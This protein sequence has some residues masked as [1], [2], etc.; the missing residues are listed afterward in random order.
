MKFFRKSCI[1]VIKYDIDGEEEALDL[2]NRKEVFRW[3]DE[4]G[5]AEKKREKS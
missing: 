5:V 2:I 1:H 3:L 4:D